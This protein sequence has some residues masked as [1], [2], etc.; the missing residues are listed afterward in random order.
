MNQL[1]FLLLQYTDKKFF[2]YKADLYLSFAG[3]STVLVDQ[4][5]HRQKFCRMSAG[6]INRTIL[7]LRL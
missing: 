6:N 4:N 2:S 5:G 3:N 7:S 1:S